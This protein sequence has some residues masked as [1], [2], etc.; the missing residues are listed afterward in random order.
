MTKHGGVPPFSE[1]RTYMD[2]IL[3]L[4]GKYTAYAAFKQGGTDYIAESDKSCQTI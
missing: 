4:V 2:K 3:G 1:T